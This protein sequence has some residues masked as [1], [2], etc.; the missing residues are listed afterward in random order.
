MGMVVL[1]EEI[2]LGQFRLRVG[3]A[4]Y[5]SL[6]QLMIFITIGQCHVQYRV[7]AADV[8]VEERVNNRQVTAESLATA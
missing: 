6:I 2:S 5:A 1:K 4:I 3:S 7:T 8:G